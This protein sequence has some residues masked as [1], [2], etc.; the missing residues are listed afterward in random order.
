MMSLNS[1]ALEDPIGSS[2]NFSTNSR[3]STPQLNKLQNF[4][5][6]C[7]PDSAGKAEPAPAG[8]YTP[9]CMERES[10]LD[11]LALSVFMPYFYKSEKKTRFVQVST[12]QR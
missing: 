7:G 6:E 12:S 9:S 11:G 8:M 10:Q 3:I 5:P 1:E 4:P 2:R